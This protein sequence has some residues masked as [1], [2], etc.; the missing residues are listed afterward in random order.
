MTRVWPLWAETVTAL[1]FNL[2]K[3]LEIK[4][5]K[6]IVLRGT[7]KRTVND[8][9][10]IFRIRWVKRFVV[11]FLILLAARSSFLRKLLKS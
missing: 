10:S 6:Y 7:E 1:E 8:T 11:N 4:L 2:P 3:S 9:K 5:F